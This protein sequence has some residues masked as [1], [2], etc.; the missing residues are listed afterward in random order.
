M[1]S[2]SGRVICCVQSLPTAHSSPLADEGRVW[3][4]GVCNFSP[5]YFATVLR[6]VNQVEVHPSI[7]PPAPRAVRTLDRPISD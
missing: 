6:A 5:T 7:Q 4:I 3:A 2:V 1:A